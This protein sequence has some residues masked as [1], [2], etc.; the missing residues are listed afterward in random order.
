MANK[1]K[2]EYDIAYDFAIKV[3][4]KFQN[5]VRSIALFGSAAKELKHSSVRDIDIVIIVDDCVVK[6]NDE[7]IAFYREELAKIVKS[8]KEGKRLHISTVTLS[9]FWEQVKLGEPVAINVLRYAQPLIDPGNFFTPLKVLLLNGRIKPTPEAVYTTLERAPMHLA[10]A[11]RGMLST[12]EDIYWA[13]TDS[14]HAALMAYKQ[15]PPSP[16]FIPAMLT[17]TFQKQGKIK[18]IYIEWYKEIYAI[19]H[20]MNQGKILEIT[21][22]HIELY[23]NRAEEF[24]KVMNNLVKDS[25]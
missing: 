6:W 11:K 8:T 3:Q 17:N 1:L 5:L 9:S 18:Q 21:G 25:E 20:H 24:V 19:V 15:T 23:M 13:M 2:K 12:I 10:R 7:L 14:A 22:K 16:E 4:K